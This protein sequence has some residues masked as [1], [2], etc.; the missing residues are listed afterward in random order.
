MWMS[1]NA[2]ES[3][4]ARNTFLPE[5]RDTSCSFP[6]QPEKIWSVGMGLG[7]T[8]KRFRQF[9]DEAIGNLV[10]RVGFWYQNTG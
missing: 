6:G 8:D 7:V 10:V 3:F 9:A 4:A 2:R 1:E 5:A